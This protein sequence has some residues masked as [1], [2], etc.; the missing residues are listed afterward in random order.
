MHLTTHAQIRWRQLA[1]SDAVFSFIEEHHDAEV[2]LGNGKWA[3]LLTD[4]LAAELLESD[5]VS[6]S[7]VENAR[8]TAVLIGE[9]GSAVVTI[10]KGAERKAFK[11]YTRARKGRRPSRRQRQRRRRNGIGR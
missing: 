7:I 5:T 1:M 8:G 11:A 6:K 4:R 3:W 2:Y 10:V 9:D